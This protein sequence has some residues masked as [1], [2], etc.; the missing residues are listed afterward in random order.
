MSP[1]EFVLSR[2]DQPREVAP[3]RWRARCPAHDGKNR[4]TLS[5]TQRDDGA[6]LLHCFAE[7]DA[8]AVVQA[9]GLDIADLF[10]PKPTAPGGGSSPMRNPFVPAQVFEVLRFEATVLYLIGCDMRRDR[11]VSAA[12]F[13]RLG[14]ALGRINNV[15]GVYHR[16]R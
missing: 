16:G 10:P 12:D 2:L 8:A 7:C 9:M 1:L 13:D 11:E 5:I 15:A 3:G 14:V 6:V 4:S